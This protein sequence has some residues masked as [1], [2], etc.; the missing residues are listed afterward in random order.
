MTIDWLQTM[1]ASKIAAVV[2]LSPYESRFSLWHRMAGLLPAQE[3]SAVLRRGHYLE[4]AVMSWFADQHP[5]WEVHPA[6]SVDPDEWT[7]LPDGRRHPIWLHCED[8]CWIA[9]PDGFAITPEDRRLV[10]IKT[11]SDTDEWGQPGTDEIPK[12]YL[13][14]VQWQMGVLGVKRTHVAVLTAYLEFREY[15]VDFDPD[16][17]AYLTAKARRFLDSLPGGPA[18]AKPDLDRH[19]ATYEAV[20]QLHPDIE[21]R[22]VELDPVLVREFCTARHAFA[23]AEARLQE[24]TSCMAAALGN[25][26][27]GVYLG[28]TIARRQAKGD[29]P[30]FLVAGR[31]LPTFDTEDQTAA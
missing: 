4:P 26:K 9:S 23:D 29:K 11:A 10:E 14:Q 21:D 20:R 19:S 25:A 18:E 3:D 16:D 7:T 17:W 8:R 30:P 12:S 6:L 22:K 5:D 1:S 31:S 28:K 15:V 24:A 2:G 27:T 13:A